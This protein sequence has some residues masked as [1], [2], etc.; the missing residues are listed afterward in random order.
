[1][2]YEAKGWYNIIRRGHFILCNT[3]EQLRPY[4]KRN[5]E[6]SKNLIVLYYILTKS[7]SFQKE[8]ATK[9]V[10]SCIV[11][12]VGRIVGCPLDRVSRHTFLLQ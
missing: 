4:V 5:Q 1:M 9:T 8:C 6:I 12:K 2:S 3:I 7:Y 11:L 10:K